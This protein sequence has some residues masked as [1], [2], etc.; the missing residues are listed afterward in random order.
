MNKESIQEHFNGNYLE[1]Y[2]RFFSA[3]FKKDG[4]EYKNNCLYHEDK[5]TP[6]FSVNNEKGTFHCFGCKEGGD[7]FTFYSKH[8]GLDTK[9]D[10]P[11]ILEGIANDFSIPNNGNR[12]QK[13]QLPSI[14][15]RYVYTDETGQPL[16][17]NCRCEGK[18]FRQ[19]RY[20]NGKWVSNLNGIRTVPFNLQEVLNSNE[21]LVCEGEKDCLNAKKLGFTATTNAGGACNWKPE[22]NQ[23]L[24]GKDVVLIPDNDEPGNRLP[25]LRSRRLRGGQQIQATPWKG[26]YLF[27][28]C[29]SIAGNKSGKVKAV[30]RPCKYG[31]R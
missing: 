15:E 19:E 21:I 22:Y 2:Q 14:I 23:Y 20:V 6:S 13:K 28:M 10:F 29:S 7:I 26:F 24:K 8:A 5:K 25:V 17:S 1:F 4:T 11:K 18:K 3:E 31:W 30:L 9:S 12:P 27:P 16:H